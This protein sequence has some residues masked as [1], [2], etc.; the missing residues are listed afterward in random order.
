M[1][2]ALWV[3]PALLS[4]GA[5]EVD[6][7]RPGPAEHRD[8]GATAPCLTTPTAPGVAAPV[9]TLHT[10]E[11]KSPAIAP[12][13]SAVPKLLQDGGDCHRQ[14][15]EH[16]ERQDRKQADDSGQHR[17][18]SQVGPEGFHLGIA[19]REIAHD[20]PIDRDRK[21]ER[22]EHENRVMLDPV[23]EPVRKTVGA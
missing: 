8:I 18:D 4:A 20:R 7:F 21:R 1:T 13:G 9:G 16:A 23:V 12:S 5:L 6:R 22:E 14:E 11:R 15:Q 19:T 3:L 10:G 2:A 17:N